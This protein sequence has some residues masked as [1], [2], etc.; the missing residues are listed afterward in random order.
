M[1]ERA[2]PAWPGH[3]SR[4]C[5]APSGIRRASIRSVHPRWGDQ[6]GP[7]AAL[8]DDRAY[9]VESHEFSG[10]SIRNRSV[11]P[12]RSGT[13]NARRSLPYVGVAA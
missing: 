12:S 5:S 8:M 2:I 9:V 11:P 6:S 1:G 10:E 13:L 4:V 3:S 7:F